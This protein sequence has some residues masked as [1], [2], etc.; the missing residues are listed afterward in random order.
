MLMHNSFSQFLPA[1]EGGCGHVCLAVEGEVH[2]SLR[3]RLY[4]GV[5]DSSSTWPNESGKPK[6]LLGPF[7][8]CFL[9]GEFCLGLLFSGD[10]LKDWY[11][12]VVTCASPT[13]G[14]CSPAAGSVWASSFLV[15][16]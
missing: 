5:G 8:A 2:T 1:G 9:S 16:P 4:S 6:L 7:S 13:P 14:N 3:N 10:P 12:A 15:T 11:L